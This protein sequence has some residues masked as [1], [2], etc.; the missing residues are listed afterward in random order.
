MNGPGQYSRH[1]K[2]SPDGSKPTSSRVQEHSLAG[3]LLAF[4]RLLKQYGFA[5][6]TPS[7]MDALAG[8]SLIGVENPHDVKAVLKASFLTRREESPIFDRLFEEFWLKRGEG[9]EQWEDIPGT[10]ESNRPD[11][12][13]EGSVEEVLVAEAT[14]SPSQKQDVWNARPYVMYSPAETLKQQDFKEIPL[15]EDPRI[16]RLIREMVAPL[17]RRKGI[18]KRPTGS[19]SAPDF[20]RI[21]RTSV[22][23]GGQVFEL[24]MLKPKRRLKKL[25]FLCDVSGSMNSY[26]RFMLRF[27]KEIQQLPTKVETFTFATR[28][29][30]ITPFLSRLPFERALQEIGRVAQDWA[31]GTRIGK[32]FGEFRLFGRERLLGPSTVILIFSDGWDRGDPELLE[33]EM[34][35]MQRRSYRL[36]WINPLLGGTGYEPTCRGMKTALPHVDSFLPG[37]NLAAMERLAGTLRSLL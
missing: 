1:S 31:G 17:M 32:C 29:H 4:G 28:V 37:H 16:S 7:L 33:K 18:R 20:R 30:R 36:L 23:Y 12:G 26:L 24:P 6:S 8:V 34:I 11:A 3:S 5:I 9:E 13:T 14:A 25:V 35:R 10:T 27:I 2:S 15:G 21:F 22:R 19:G